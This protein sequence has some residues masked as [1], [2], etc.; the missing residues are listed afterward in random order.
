MF[1]ASTASGDCVG[2]CGGT[3]IVTISNLVLGVNIN[4]G[5][6]PASAC[7]AFQNA[8]GKVDITQL[9]KG[10]NNALIG[11]P[12]VTG[13][14]TRTTTP[15][16]MT[17][18]VPT[19]TSTHTPTH[20]LGS[21][22]THTPMPTPI[23]TP[24]RTPSNTSTNTP[25][26]TLTPTPDPSPSATPF[27]Q[28]IDLG[29]VGGQPCSTTEVKFSISD[30]LGFTVSALRIDFCVD[31]TAFKVQDVTCSTFSASVS[32][33]SVEHSP[34]CNL[35]DP[36][37]PAGQV[38][39]NAHGTGGDSGN[40]FQPFDSVDCAIPVLPQTA[41]GSYP[42]RYRLAATT[43]RGSVINVGEGEIDVFGL[44]PTD[45]FQGECCTSDAQCSSGFCRNGDATQYA[46]CCES[47][48]ATG[49][50]NAQSFPGSCCAASG[51][52]SFCDPP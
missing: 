7:P 38:S 3:G 8:Q 14:E 5:L 40:A 28:V 1:A 48:C 36:L 15:T 16:G 9:V 37:N 46:A 43:S 39:V 41:G 18:E 49:V 35:D 52:P 22:P 51:L 34:S 27:A 25:A 47:D 21:T 13:T 31:A 2:D 4:L 23:S 10:V 32:V 19:S 24:T 33:D 11:C 42:I 30:G 20:T 6:Q 12:P 26:R 17:T 50:C 44:A 45:R 29:V